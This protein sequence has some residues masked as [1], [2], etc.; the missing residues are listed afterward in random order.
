[1]MSLNKIDS[2]YNTKNP[3]NFSEAAKL[4]TTFWQAINPYKFIYCNI[5]IYISIHLSIHL[6]VCTRP[7]ISP[8]YIFLLSVSKGKTNLWAIQFNTYF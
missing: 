2:Y 6:S 1:M 3:T 8:S 5:Y 7:E 4:S